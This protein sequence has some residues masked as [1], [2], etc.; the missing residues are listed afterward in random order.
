MNPFFSKSFTGNWIRHFAPRHKVVR[1]NFIRPMEFVRKKFSPYYFNVGKNLTNGIHYTI[2]SNE[3]DFKGKVLLI[4][5]V[6]QYFHEQPK[7]VHKRLKIKKVPQYKGYLSRLDGYKDIDGYL[8]ENL[9]KKGRYKV[10]DGE[11]K[12]AKQHRIDFKVFTGPVP[13]NEYDIVMSALYGILSKRW[14]DLGKDNDILRDRDY[15]YDLV[16]D[17]MLSNKASLNVLYADDTIIAVSLCFLSSKVLY[18][19]ITSFDPDYSKYSLGHV[20]IGKIM[21]WCI[22]NGISYFDYSKGDNDYKN[23]WATDSYLFENHILYDKGSVS[24]FLIGN[25]LYYFYRFKQEL[26][27]KKINVVYSKL[28]YRLKS[29]GLMHKN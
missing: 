14:D 19:A 1:L 6:H 9:S 12:L 18:F 17:M 3:S 2:D 8:L 7:Q 20:I 29:I 11:K 22:D 4:H 23:R 13:K 27:D 28:K 5:D 26:R 25:Y 24:A 21:K 16:Y 15:Y 10:R